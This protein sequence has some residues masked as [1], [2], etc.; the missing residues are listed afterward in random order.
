MGRKMRHT[1]SKDLF[2]YWNQ[3]RGARAAP[4]RGDIDPAAIRHVLADS[5]ILEIDSARLFPIR[6]CGTRVNA[7]KLSEQK[8]QSFL[9]LWRSEDRRSVASALL[10]VIDDVAPV[11]AGVRALAPTEGAAN[12][13]ARGDMSFELLLLPLRHFG[14][15]HSRVLGSLSSREPSNWFGKTAAPPLSLISMRIIRPE[16][17]KEAIATRIPS[18]GVSF[19]TKR[20]PHFVVY[21][22]GKSGVQSS[23]F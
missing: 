3:L 21:Q 8:G 6:L 16:E 23:L 13:M 14:K 1:V 4:D 2:A 7:L 18:S 22:G 19:G 10:T 5:F 20:G 17:A 9:D 11:V 15:T 12:I